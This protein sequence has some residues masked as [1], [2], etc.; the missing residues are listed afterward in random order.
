MDAVLIDYLKSG[1]AWVIIGSGPSNEMGYPSWGELASIASREARL[2]GRGADFKALDAA[3]RKRDYPLVFQEAGNIL[4]I[5]LLLEILQGSLAPRRGGNIYKLMAQWPVPVYL[6]TNYDDEIQ[7]QLTAV[8]E[9]YITYDNSEEHFANLLPDLQGAVFKLHGDLRSERGLILTKR[10]Y[11]QIEESDEWAYWR[12]KLTS[13]FQM[14]RVV[15]V[16]HSLSDTNIRSVFEAAKQGA[17]V[18]QPICWLAP[19]VS[20]AESK[21]FLEKY[22]IRVIS[23]PNSDGT[24]RNLRH[25]LENVSRFLPQR[26]TIHIKEAIAHVSNPPLAGDAGAPAFYVFNKL[27]AQKDYEEKRIDVL[28]ASLQSILPSITSSP[29]VS[30]KEALELAGWP[31]DTPLPLALEEHI[32]RRAVEV[33]LMAEGGELFVPSDE[34]R[35]AAEENR[36]RFEHS[37]ERFKTSLTV[38]LRRDYP[39][40]SA[41]EVDTIVKDIES[42]LT[43][44]FREGGLTLASTL[45]HQ[46]KDNEPAVPSSIIDFISQASARYDDLLKR[47]AFVTISTDIFT[48]SESAEKDYLGRIS[49]GFFAFHSLGVLG[50]LAYERFKRAQ[51]TVWLLDSN[52]QIPALAL[53]SPTNLL[54]VDTLNRLR[55]QGIRVFTTNALFKETFEHLNFAHTVVTR[56]GE[57]SPDVIAGARGDA[58]YRRKNEFLQGFIRWQAAGNPPEWRKYIYQMLGQI[59]PTPRATRQALQNLGVEIFNFEDWPGFTVR[60]NDEANQCVDRIVT[61][62]EE[63]AVTYFREDLLETTEDDLTYVRMRKAEPEAEA[64]VIVTKERGG[65]YYMLTEEGQE[66]PAW[67]IS[68]TAMLNL[69]SPDYPV[70][71]RP[72]S[73]LSFTTTLAQPQ[74]S[75]S[76]ERAFET[77]LWNCAETGLSLIDERIVS[78]VFGGVIDQVT[79]SLREEAQIYEDTLGKK[80]GESVDAI[81]ERIS[82]A[83]KLLAAVQLNNERTQLQERLKREADA[84]AAEAAR[85]ASKAEKKLSEVGKFIEQ[86]EVKKR[87]GKRKARKQRSK[88]RKKK[89]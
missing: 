50:D 57:T 59:T 8:G 5:P 10:Q 74:D 76:T 62:L 41:D 69:L 7:R 29:A 78:Q 73:F 83:N 60:D 88:P 30:L 47:Q 14:N 16:G 64:F 43:G 33:G 49:Q 6:T 85:R 38:R 21:L 79:L 72:E 54:I 84:R 22:R 81:L 34:A 13:I 24:H 87:S 58:P 80:Y 55:S 51:E 75:R 39:A 63:R 20:L 18:K 86:M 26:T 56:N 27:A 4:G 37:R 53:G 2:A 35:A 1:K 67:F 40:L 61:I 45:Y 11:E 12:I 65:D 9:T 46:A 52:A 42:S 19:D 25:V 77:I 71:W 68:N 44:Y 36:R 32:R 70:T 15:V 48:R 82:P 89:R 17:G 28:L 31:K 66:S 23:Y 3:E